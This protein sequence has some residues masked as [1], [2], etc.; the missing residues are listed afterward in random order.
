MGEQLMYTLIVEKHC[1]IIQGKK[2]EFT[3]HYRTQ[4]R[5]QVRLAIKPQG[6]WVGQPSVCVLFDVFK[7]RV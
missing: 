4:R 2:D 1:F 6:T 3:K 7:Y 5:K